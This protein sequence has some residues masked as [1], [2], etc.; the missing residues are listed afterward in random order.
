M[1]AV[2]SPNE[3][4][5]ELVDHLIQPFVPNIPSCIRDRQHFLDKQHARCPL[6]V[7]SILCT[8]DVAAL[9]P[10]IP[11]DDRLANL[12]NALLEHSIATLT[13]T[14]ICDMN[15]LVLRRNVFEFNK[16]YFIQTSGTA[17]GT[18]LAPSYANLFS[19]IFERDLL[20]EYPIK[21]SIWLRYIDDIFMTWNESEDKLNDFLAYINTVNPAIQFTH[22]HSFKSV[23]LLDVL[24]ALTD[25]GTIS[26]DLLGK[27]ADA[28]W[29]L[30]MNSC[31]HKN[32]MKAIAFSQATQILCICS[33]P[34]TA[35]S[36]C[37]E[38]I[39]Y[40]VRRGHGR[41]HTQLVVQRAIDAYR[42]PQQHIRNIDSGVYFIVQYHTGQPDIKVNLGKSL[43]ILYT[44][45]RMSIVFSRPPVVSFYQPKNPSQQRQEPQKDAIQSNHAKAIAAIM[46]RLCFC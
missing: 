29:Y 24:V 18:K 16:E 36:R 33:D 3:G 5:S 19:P 25:D 31:H 30:H 26:T 38:L 6:P 37:N 28:H 35:Q 2:G 34:A 8:I 23:D 41:R 15:E 22:A 14:S 21:P 45:K 10:R 46:Y 27:H 20:D 12:R 13:I 9:Y 43:P 39:Q 40:L 11:H 42:N 17:I 32:V 4:L 7:D 1:S 44:S